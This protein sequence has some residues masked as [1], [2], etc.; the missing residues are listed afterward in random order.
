[1]RDVKGG[2]I[3]IRID[4]FNQERYDE[5]RSRWD[6]V[7]KPLDSLGKFEDITARIG[8]VHDSVNIDIH[9]RAVIM[10][11]ADNGIVEEGVSQSGQDVTAA[12]AGWMGKG[13]SSVCKMAKV[14]KADTIPV[15]IGINMDG[16]P[17]GVID[18]KVMRGTRNFAHEPAMTEDEC[19]Q[20]IDAGIDIVCDCSAKGYKLLA[21]GEMGIGNT[22]TSS[23]LAAALLGLDA[24]DVTGHG[25]GLSTAGLSKKIRV[26][27]EALDR[28]CPEDDVDIYS[29]EYAVQ[30]L[31]CVGGLDIAGLTGVF[32]GGALMHIPVII[33]G[34]ISSVAALV[35]ERMV[36]GAKYYMIASHV[37]KE[38]GME[39]ILNELGLDAV[40]HGGLAL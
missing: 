9:K 38:P 8:A 30:M 5:I 4:P 10:M 21:T 26:V 37:G 22:T 15:D 36:P 6:K 39:Y 35:A 7:A 25:A 31:A 40:I 1:M 33:D 29:P 19:M 32:I 13:I 14:C 23:A 16:S 24:G 27:R 34:F 17:K 12:V 20:A 3:L 2:S 18:R 28:Y 11:C